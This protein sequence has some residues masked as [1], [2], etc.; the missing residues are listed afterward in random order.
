MVAYQCFTATVAAI[1]KWYY[2]LFDEGE[3]GSSQIPQNLLIS[4]D[5]KDLCSILKPQGVFGLHFENQ[6][7]EDLSLKIWGFFMWISWF[8]AKIKD[9]CH[10]SQYA[11][12]TM[13]HSWNF[14]SARLGQGTFWPDRKSNPEPLTRFSHRLTLNFALPLPLLSV[15]YLEAEIDSTCNGGECPCTD[16]CL[17][18]CTN[19]ILS[20]AIVHTMDVNSRYGAWRVKGN[21]SWNGFS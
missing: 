20:I 12:L 10:R 19:F 14:L 9:G 18:S 7:T 11:Y 15:D 5:A 17:E 6:P 2:K 3:S 13:S 16:G 21:L 4:D 1:F 8:Q